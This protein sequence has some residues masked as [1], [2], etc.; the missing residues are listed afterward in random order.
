MTFKMPRTVF[1]IKTI[2]LSCALR[3]W[4]FPSSSSY[5]FYLLL[6]TQIWVTAASAHKSQCHFVSAWGWPFI[7][8]Y[9]DLYW[10]RKLLMVVSRSINRTGA[11]L[12]KWTIMNSSFAVWDF[13]LRD[14]ERVRGDRSLAVQKPSTLLSMM[15]LTSHSPCTLGHLPGH[16]LPK[17]GVNCTAIN[18]RLPNWD[19][20][21]Q[22][23]SM[24]EEE[25]HWN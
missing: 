15:D 25:C 18:C 7:T 17:W 20:N 12:C 5:S 10:E 13:E 24:A 21:V 11:A 19:G 9:E 14:W 4:A 8:K 1:A 16:C 2:K 23:E 6:W 22:G 3:S